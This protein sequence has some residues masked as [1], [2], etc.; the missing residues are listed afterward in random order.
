[1]ALNYVN[2]NIIKQLI[3]TGFF[4]R[5]C[6]FQ[7]Y[8]FCSIL[9]RSSFYFNCSFLDM[10]AEENNQKQFHS[11]TLDQSPS[12]KYRH[13]LSLGCVSVFRFRGMCTW[14]GTYVCD[15]ANLRT[16]SCFKSSC[17]H[18]PCDT[19][20]D[21]SETGPAPEGCIQIHL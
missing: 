4:H 21:S 20:V 15:Q 9:S 11:F 3:L 16:D 6:R 5:F 13:E 19:C 7:H 10:I 14:V 2:L 17:G 18:R 8:L 12:I 1:M